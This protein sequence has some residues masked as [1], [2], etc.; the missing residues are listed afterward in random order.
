ELENF[1]AASIS[2]ELR[3]LHAKRN[4]L[5]TFDEHSLTPEEQVDRRILSGIVD[6][7]ILELEDVRSWQR[8]PMIYVAA[9]SDGLHDL[10]T[11]ESDS[12][13]VRMR[14]VLGKLRTLPALLSAARTTTPTPPLVFVESAFSRLPGVQY[15]RRHALPLAFA[16]SH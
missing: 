10:I 15:R 9:L 16:T 3:W 4:A 7:W 12:A 8:N 2:Q 1:S 13:E 5:D 14:H 6:G 11:M